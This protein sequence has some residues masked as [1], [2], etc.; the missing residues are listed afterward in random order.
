LGEAVQELQLALEL[1]RSLP[2]RYERARTLLAY[3]TVA[4][5]ARRKRE[6]R[7]ALEEAAA[8]F[9]DV[10]AFRWDERTRAEL[11]RLGGRAPAGD[12]LTQTESRVAELVAEGLRDREA[13]ERLFLTEKTV[14]FHL[15][16]VF[17]KLGSAPARSSP[18]ALSKPRDSIVSPGVVAS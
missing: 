17:R 18:A 3:G 15:R 10:G 14:E 13:A 2:E 1:H 7:H 5:R 16:N 4:R 8:V 12:A 9:A 6:A 11:G